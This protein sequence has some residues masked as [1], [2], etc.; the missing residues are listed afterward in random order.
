MRRSRS[1][2]GTLRLRAE[3]VAGEEVALADAG[4]GGSW[5]GCRKNPKLQKKGRRG[6]VGRRGSSLVA[7]RAE[8][9]GDQSPLGQI[10]PASQA[11]SRL[12]E[13]EADSESVGNWG[14]GQYYGPRC[15]GVE[16]AP[17]PIS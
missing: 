14:R 12:S 15:D 8:G 2:R 11:M 6:L 9:A 3:A 16:N 7:L 17:S 4:D 5:E 13:A 1:R 10:P